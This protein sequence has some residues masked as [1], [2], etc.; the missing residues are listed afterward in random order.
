MNLITLLSIL[1][2]F[3]AS[4]S[5]Y[6]M[7][8]YRRLKLLKQRVY[9]ASKA[10]SL[11][12]QKLA[13]EFRNPLNGITGFSEMLESGY[14]G[15]LAHKQQECVHDIYICG[16]QL[17]SLVKDLIDLS[18]G[19]NGVIELIETSTPL[20]SLIEKAMEEIKSKISSNRIRVLIDLEPNNYEII[21]DQNK[22]TQ[23]FKNVIDN[24]VKFSLKGGQ[25]TIKQSNIQG[26]FVKISIADS[27]IGMNKDELDTIF[28]F[29]DDTRKAKSLN[30]GLGM[31]MP[32]TKF[33]IELHNGIVKVDSE[34]KLGTTVT[35]L[36]PEAAVK[37]T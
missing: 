17:Q 37:H 30:N 2:V 22:L 14:F 21:G 18:K 9:L 13:Y 29:P 32:L 11:F 33:F 28:L 8:S 15:E 10:K 4:L 16:N 3:F 1:T 27:G 25:V 23:A 5:I 26:K 31:G 19:E 36:L 20:A 24:A 6:L 12:M 35:I 7:K 34:D